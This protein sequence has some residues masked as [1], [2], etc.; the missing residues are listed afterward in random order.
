M[1]ARTLLNKLMLAA[2]CYGLF[3]PACAASPIDQQVILSPLNGHYY[4]WIG[5]TPLGWANANAFAD[6]YSSNFQG[7]V[8][9]DWHLA[10]ITSA[11]ENDYI[12]NSILDGTPHPNAGESEIWLGANVTDGTRTNFHWVTGEAFA[13]THFAPGQ[14]DFERESS[15]EMWGSYGEYWNNDDPLEMQSFI[16]EHPSIAAVPEP[17]TILLMLAGLGLV[18]WMA[19]RRKQADR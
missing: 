10:T 5:S 13:Y 16:L 19:Q 12:Y 7:V 6:S 4:V 17:S 1:F 14:P 9:S 3:L 11:E 2:G 18:G 8:L 15:L